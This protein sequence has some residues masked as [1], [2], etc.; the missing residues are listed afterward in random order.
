MNDLESLEEENRFETLTFP[1]EGLPSLIDSNE[2]LNQICI[3]LQNGTGPIAIDA[4]RASS[5]RYSARAYLIQL[6]RQNSGT[7]LIDPI[8]ISD[9][10]QLSNVLSEAEWILHAATQDL[11]CLAEVGLKPTKLFDTEHAGRLLGKPRVG[12]AAL[13]ESEM[14][15]SLAKE[16]SAADWSTRPLPEPWLIYAALDVE[17][18][19]EL[20]EILLAQLNAKNRLH[21]AE[22]E[23]EY[24]VG[25][26][27]APALPEPWRKTSGIHKVRHPR[28]LAIIR[29][30]WSER[31][32]IAQERDKS[33]SKVLPD[34][35][36][37]DIAKNELKS[38]RDVYMLE[39]L[40]NRSHKAF[41]DLW[42]EVRQYALSLDEN[43]LPKASAGL[44]SIPPT[45][46]WEEKN[47]EA[48]ERFSKV[49]PKVIEIS[50]THEV[51][52]EIIISPEVIR[53]LCWSG[54]EILTTETE[55][56]NWL[57]NQNA[58]QWQAELLSSDVFA[59]LFD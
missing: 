11:A 37:I 26:K 13:L 5:F 21:W 12:L 43:E 27:P 18:L 56:Q 15:I 31:D 1:S 38:A 17:K 58:R 25:W 35:A 45:K 32:R 19:V 34:A 49:R 3:E 40:R 14:Q 22:Q 9:F 2:G 48:H 23:F 6:R 33:V 20:R 36:I 39:T 42:W 59:L 57:L 29:E 4:E 55:L 52:P 47:P 51:A 8:S 44:N 41:A 46:A 53:Q 7:Y 54:Y 50:E 30:L 10:S 16:H 24:L 28:Q